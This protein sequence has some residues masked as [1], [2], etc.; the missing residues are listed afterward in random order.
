MNN[1]IFLNIYNDNYIVFFNCEKEKYK[2]IKSLNYKII[3]N[4]VGVINNKILILLGKY[5]IDTLIIDLNYLEIVQIIKNIRCHLFINENSL[6]KII[7]NDNGEIEK[8]KNIFD[9]REGNFKISEITKIKF[10]LI[11]FSKMLLTN[12]EYF[13]FTNEKEIYIMKL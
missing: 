13:I 7:F 1:S 8:E 10:N 11:S 6:I 5:G 4:S 12:D 3:F 2:I 9:F